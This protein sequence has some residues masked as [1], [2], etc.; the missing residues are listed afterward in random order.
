MTLSSKSCH[1]LALLVGRHAFSARG[2]ETERGREHCSA[3]RS[4]LQNPLGKA[5]IIA[6]VWTV[7]QPHRGNVGALPCNYRLWLKAGKLS[8]LLG[9]RKREKSYAY[10]L[11]PEGSKSLKNVDVAIT[12]GF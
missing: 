10:L 5:P 7:R 1:T 3:L 2:P 11:T 4:G 6:G 9:I 12:L 8:C